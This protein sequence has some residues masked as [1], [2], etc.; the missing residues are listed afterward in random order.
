MWGW[1]LQETVENSRLGDSKKF[2]SVWRLKH[3]EE[4]K[5]RLKRLEL[6]RGHRLYPSMLEEEESLVQTVG[7]CFGCG[8]DVVTDPE[9]L[10]VVCV[11][12]GRVW[13]KSAG[14]NRIPIE[15]DNVA[16]GHA[17]GSYN[18]ITHLEFLGGLGSKVDTFLAADVLGDCGD[19]PEEVRLKLEEEMLVQ[20]LLTGKRLT[21]KNGKFR[22]PFALSRAS[23]A[24]VPLTNSLLKELLTLGS[25][26]CKKHGFYRSRD[27]HKLWFS[28]QVGLNL[29]D[30]GRFYASGRGKKPDVWRLAAS[31]FCLLFRQCFP[32]RYNSIRFGNDGESEK[33]FP[34][35]CLPDAT[36]KY[37]E[38]ILESCNPSVLPV[39]P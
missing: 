11:C 2:R 20:F 33:K 31:I 9:T 28:D 29:I 6:L 18:P 36:L 8:D 34:E 32:E 23:H 37:Y 16:G 13:G 14:E 1:G 12:C 19:M 24:Q 3:E 22:S 30:V 10:E 35:L 21:V 15:E 7:Y 17:E 25:D 39:L 5:D 4:K 38:V 26:F 27:L